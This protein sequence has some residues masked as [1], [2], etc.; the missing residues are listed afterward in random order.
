MK[1][2][3]TCEISARE[4]GQRMDD[5]DLDAQQALLSILK[6]KGAPVTGIAIFKA[7]FDNYIWYKFDDGL[8]YGWKKK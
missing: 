5:Y 1:E 4:W 2:K 3:G 8:K 6:D 7:D